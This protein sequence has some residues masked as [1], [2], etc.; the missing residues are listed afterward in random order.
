MDGFGATYLAIKYPSK[1][2]PRKDQPNGRNS[3]TD[4]S[5]FNFFFI[6]KVTSR[7]KLYNYSLVRLP[8]NVVLKKRLLRG[9]FYCGVISS[10]ISQEMNEVLWREQMWTEVVDRK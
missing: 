5:P 2:C 9:V 10:F 3:S 6:K 4:N 8:T 1:A 7:L